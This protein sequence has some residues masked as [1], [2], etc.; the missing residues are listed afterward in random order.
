MKN[1]G[2]H[3]VFGIVKEYSRIATLVTNRATWAIAING[4]T[5]RLPGYCYDSE[6]NPDWVPKC[7]YFV[8]DLSL[9]L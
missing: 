1:N 6:F 5:V 3:L 8:P 9:I 2:P 7:R 4:W